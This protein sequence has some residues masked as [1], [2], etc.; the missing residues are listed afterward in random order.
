M[1]IMRRY[2]RRLGPVPFIRRLIELA[3]MSRAI[4]GRRNGPGRWGRWFGMGS[5]AWS[6]GRRGVASW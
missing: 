1:L 4:V 6:L 5:A 3:V 2:N